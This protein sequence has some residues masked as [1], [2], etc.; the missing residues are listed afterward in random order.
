LYNDPFVNTLVSPWVD[1]SVSF[2]QANLETGDAV[3]AMADVDAIY[4]VPLGGFTYHVQNEAL[5][6]WFTRNPGAPAVGPGPGVYSWPNT[7]TLNNGHNPA[8]W[9]YGEGPAGFFFGP[10]F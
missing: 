9:V 10:P 7:N 2:A 3:E 5:L 6:Q 1:G 8:G 4:H